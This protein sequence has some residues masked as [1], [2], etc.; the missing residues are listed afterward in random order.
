METITTET[1]EALLEKALR[2][3]TASIEA[4]NAEL[5]AQV[6]VLSEKVAAH[7]TEIA[8]LKEENERVNG[9]LDKAQVDLRVAQDE[10]SA[11]KADID[12]K[13]EEARLA[14]I[15][16]E[17]ASQ[18]RNLALFT[19]DF[20]TERA[21]RWAGLDEETWTERLDEW[22][23]AKGQTTGAP[24][25]TDHASAMTGSSEIPSGQEPSARRAALGLI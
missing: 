18:V 22:K 25:S 13:A 6:A 1:H 3:A 16:N 24:V 23:T 20:I 11:L 10:S 8:S 7:E 17:R 14:E 21:A 19:E 2:D 15:S 5:I 12:A 9:D 4:E